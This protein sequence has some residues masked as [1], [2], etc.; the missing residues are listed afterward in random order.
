MCLVS[1]VAI[2]K[3]YNSENGKHFSKSRVSY[4]CFINCPA[5]K[6]ISLWPNMYAVH[7]VAKSHKNSSHMLN[8]P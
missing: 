3:L 7:L 5:S 2:E 4:I 8:I 6:A 1:I